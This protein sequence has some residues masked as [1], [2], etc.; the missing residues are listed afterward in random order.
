MSPPSSKPLIVD[1]HTHIYPPSYV[2]LLASR[3]SVPYIHKPGGADP[4]LIILASDDDASRPMEARGRPI[5]VSYSS[6]DE[7]RKFMS[8]HGID[9]SVV[10]LANPWLDFLDPT[11]ALD[12]AQR[13]NDD[14]ND[15]CVENDRSGAP[16]KLFTFGCLPL[17]APSTQITMEIERLKSLS[18]TKGVIMG[19]TGLGS[20]LDD[21]AMSQI[22]SVLA[23]TGTVVFLHPHYG[24][25]DAAFGGPQ[26][27]AKS[28]HVLPLALGF[29]LETTI[30]IARMYLAGVFDQHAK[31]QMLLAHSGGT[32]PFLAGR[33]QSC[34]DHE[35]EFLANG[36]HKQGPKRDIWDVLRTNI[37]LDAVIYGKPGLKAAIEAGGTDRVMFGTDHPFFPPLKET[38]GKWLSVES[39][40]EA[41][42]DAE[43]NAVELILGRNAVRVLGLHT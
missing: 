20:G 15:A 6:W 31:L 27:I 1:V 10:S 30:A 41:I 23:S 38:H 19:T 35:R 34:V 9:V 39:N 37:Y 4:R 33:I 43:D 42:G 28:G 25:P 18:H 22:W 32:L 21:P 5:D 26:I 24:L 17:S 12:T 7:K 2:D 3:S 36:G 8:L 13:I 40:R 14:M 29:P 11:T 16:C